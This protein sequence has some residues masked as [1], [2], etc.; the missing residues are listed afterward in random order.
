MNE[1]MNE[2]TNERTNELAVGWSYTVRVLY[3]PLVPIQLGDFCLQ[4]TRSD[5]F[6]INSSRRGCEFSTSIV[7]KLL[8]LAIWKMVWMECRSCVSQVCHGYTDWWPWWVHSLV[9]RCIGIGCWYRRKLQCL[10]MIGSCAS[11]FHESNDLVHFYR[12]M[13]SFQPNPFIFRQA[14]SSLGTNWV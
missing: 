10:M 6:S 7:K 4:S 11:C 2:W 5:Q 9:E 1:W 14:T 13:N 8:S 3:K 12:S